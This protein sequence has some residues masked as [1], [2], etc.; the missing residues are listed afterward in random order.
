MGRAGGRP[1][2]IAKSQLLHLQAR[3]RRT[4]RLG[5]CGLRFVRFG[6]M[7]FGFCA[8]WVYAV[9]VLCG[10]GLCGLGF[11]RFGFMRQRRRRVGWWQKR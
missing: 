1:I 8:V 11:V 10:L 4:N 9:W 3:N 2:A 5:L 7:R 6:F